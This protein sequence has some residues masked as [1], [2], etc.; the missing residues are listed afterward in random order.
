MRSYFI[1]A[2]QYC[3]ED[4]GVVAGVCDEEDGKGLIWLVTAAGTEVDVVRNIREMLV[5]LWDG[6][7]WG[8]LFSWIT[9]M[10]LVH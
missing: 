8:I 4:E 10:E 1:G 7:W 5:F 9:F 6:T 2:D 3:V